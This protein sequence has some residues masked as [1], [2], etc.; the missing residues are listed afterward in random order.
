MAIRKYAAIAIAASVMLGTAG[1]TFI[2]PIATRVEYTPTDG[3]QGDLGNVKL[4]N[5]AYLTNGTASALA[6][7]IA[8]SGLTSETVTIS[9]TDATVNEQKQV[10]VTVPAGQTLSL[11]YNGAEALNIDLGGKAGDVVLINASAG[12]NSRELRVPVLDG[13]FE[14]YKPII[15]RIGSAPAAKK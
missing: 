6:G 12:A 10:S 14:Y 2:S 15:E 13:K 4:R 8:N 1:C 9:Y 5:F 3:T 7:V 11:G